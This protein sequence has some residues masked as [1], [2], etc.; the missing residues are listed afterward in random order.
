MSSNVN[1]SGVPVDHDGEPLE[2]GVV[3]SKAGPFAISGNVFRE[4]FS[5]SGKDVNGNHLE[6]SAVEGTPVMGGVKP[7]CYGG[8]P[9]ENIVTVEDYLSSDE[10][11]LSPS[12]AIQMCKNNTSATVHAMMKTTKFER[13]ELFR[14]R[15]KLMG[16]LKFLKSKGFFEEMIYKE[17]QSNGVGAS[18][19]T[20]D[21]FGLPVSEPVTGKG[22]IPNPFVEKMK[23]KVDL[24]NVPEV[25]DG[26]PKPA[27]KSPSAEHDVSPQ[28]QSTGDHKSWSQ[29][30]KNASPKVIE[31]P[32]FSFVPP[33]EGDSKVVPPD[34]DL[35]E[36]IDKLKTTIIGSFT[37]GTVPYK[38]V[39]DFANKVWK[40]RGLIYVGQ[41]DARTFLFR[42][43][44]I[45]D[46]NNA[47]G[48]G[49]WYIERKPMVVHAWGT[50]VSTIKTM[51]LWVRFDQVPDSYW[52]VNCL[53]RLASVIGP[54]LCADEL[55]FRLEILPFAKICVQYSVGDDLPSSI[56]VTVM[57]PVTGGKSDVVVLVSYP[58]KP[59]VCSACK[60]LGHLVGACPKTTRTWV[61]KDR[62]EIA[63]TSKD[64]VPEPIPTPVSNPCVVAPVGTSI[65]AAPIGSPPAKEV[66]TAMEDFS[67]NSV[68]PGSAFKNLKRIDECAP[69]CT[70]E[71]GF[72][73]S[74]AQRKK[75]R[76]SQG[77]SSSPTPKS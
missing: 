74:K 11:P 44:S 52:T 76:R 6:A 75:M 70:S 2:F 5:G 13:D 12:S 61:R 46:M 14:A 7:S 49:T 9:L 19:P 77:K 56:P 42:F 35:K 45:T 23:E 64:A 29:V 21:D 25:F 43:N 30:V 69:L 47:L 38:T 65:P 3:D 31:P 51:P 48:K 36:G 8:I 10:E 1:S 71:P 37:K 41:K 22:P 58:N 68:S 27:V 20:R 73:P 18:L 60:S 32:K 72:Q 62:A 34:D 40:S 53:S 24:C 50:S 57:D 66:H 39:V 59:L 67:D 17:M 55:T 33:P 15:S 54:P 26:M 4:L 16:I 63:Q 28:L